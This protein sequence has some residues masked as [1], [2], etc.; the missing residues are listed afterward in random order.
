[1]RALNGEFRS[2][3]LY[4]DSTRFRFSNIFSNILGE[5]N[6]FTSFMR[7]IVIAWISVEPEVYTFKLK[8]FKFCFR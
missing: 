5:T 3:A 1:M 6:R 7:M 2:V 8:Y 4:D